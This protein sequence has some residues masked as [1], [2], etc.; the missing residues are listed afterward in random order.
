MYNSWL[1]SALEMFCPCVI[2]LFRCSTSKDPYRDD[3]GSM[4][5]SFVFVCPVDDEKSDEKPGESKALMTVSNIALMPQDSSI[6]QSDTIRSSHRS[7]D[8][9]SNAERRANAFDSAEK[10]SL[11]VSP[12][13]T[14]TNIDRFKPPSDLSQFGLRSGMTYSEINA[15]MGGLTSDSEENT[16]TTSRGGSQAS[17]LN[18]KGG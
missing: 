12:L 7:N 1:F 10:D 2:P 6:G 15:L 13:T 8:D 11:V 4:E 16:P 18:S 9:G 14:N 5:D 3:Y 17:S